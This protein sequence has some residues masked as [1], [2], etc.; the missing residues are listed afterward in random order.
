[1][2]KKARD[3]VGR[4][5]DLHTFEDDEERLVHIESLLQG[6][7]YAVRQCDR[8]KRPEVSLDQC[9]FV[10]IAFITDVGTNLNDPRNQ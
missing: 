2:I 8:T 6:H 7:S 5:Y 9:V 4:L 1:M 3:R 10:Y